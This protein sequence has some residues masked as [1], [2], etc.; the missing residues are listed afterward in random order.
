MEQTFKNPY[1]NITY[2]VM[3]GAIISDPDNK[4]ASIGQVAPTTSPT[5]TTTAPKTTLTSSGGLSPIDL[6]KSLQTTTQPST[7]STFSIPTGTYLKEGTY[8]ND[9]VKQLQSLLGITSD[10]DYG[11]LTKQA[12]ID[13]QKKAGITVDG[14]VG[15]QTMEALNKMYGTSTAPATST[16]PVKT[17]TQA[18]AESRDEGIKRIQDELNQ[19]LDKP[20]LYKSV[21]EFDKLRK[22]Q[23]IVADEEELAAIQNE[24]RLMK[25]ELRQFS[26]NQGKEVSEGGRIGAISE[27]ERNANFRMEGL[28]L[29]EQAVLA[30]VQS[31]N[32]YI[33]TAMQLMGQDYDR[34]YQEYNN[35]FSKN[36]KAIDLYNEQLNDQQKD[37]LTAFETISNLVSASGKALTPQLSQQ[38]DS[39]ALQAGLPTGLF[40]EAISGLQANEKMDNVK[41]VGDNVYMWTTDASGTPHLKLIQSLLS[42]GGGG[43]VTDLNIKDASRVQDL[44]LANRGDDGY[45]DPYYYSELR[46]SSRLSG[47]EF[48]RKFGYLVNPTS[49]TKFGVG[50]GQTGVTAGIQEADLQSILDQYGFS[51]IE[52]LLNS[53]DVP[54]DVLIKLKDLI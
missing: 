17:S 54:L 1:T 9:S 52:E 2:N 37:A 28:A 40:Q 22:E 26:A 18:R 49:K 12:V 45:V 31:K 14:I 43:T 35:E 4:A 46:S 25:Q 34:A 30:R 47:T 7:S 53:D 10:G 8:N 21:D 44:L 24:A 39:L 51:S 19:G 29:R 41:I 48:D 23:G 32:S 11:P 33:Q 16:A 50:T 20:A 6:T 13:F 36:L 5:S 42:D 27:A 3:T 15:P 38:L